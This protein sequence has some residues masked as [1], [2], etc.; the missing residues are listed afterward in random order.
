MKKLR[1]IFAIL[2][3]AALLLTLGACHPKNEV[4]ITAKDKKSGKSV[5]LTTAEYLYALTTATQEAQSIITES[6][7][8][9][10]IKD[11][12]KQKVEE[13]NENGK[14]T[15]TEYYKWIEARAEEILRTYAGISIKQE[16]LKLE[17]DEAAEANIESLVPMLYSPIYEQNG[18]GQETY[19]KLAKAG[20]DEM[21]NLYGS[22]YG[23]STYKELYF[24]SIYDEKGSNPV[25][26]ATIESYFKD[27]FVLGNQISI[28]IAEKS[29]D[30]EEATET[31]G[32]TEKEAKKLLNGYKERIEKGESFEKVF[33]EYAKKYET[34]TDES[35]GETT[36][37][38][39]EEAA[40]VYAS[41]ETGDY[42]SEFFD[43][44][45]KLKTGDVKVILSED[46]TQMILVE[47][48]NI[49]K[50]DEYLEG[51]HNLILHLLKDEEFNKD[52][53]KFCKGL[54]LEKH[55]RAYNRIDVKDIDLTVET[56]ETEE[57]TDTEESTET[58]ED[59]E[60]HNHE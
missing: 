11:F 4:A 56:P 19:T 22:Y 49:S 39:A 17:F 60:G 54:D 24:L 27:N 8:D 53:E 33:D 5:D 47:K 59:H 46:K 25:D 14:K 40:T 30:A 2:L 58:E 51:Y 32:M 43:A 48:Q 37:P 36:T 6:N 38:S 21:V 41:E 13:T 18:V 34:T 42:A 31:E 12:S 20:V 23:L 52:L 1:G 16:D 45:N 15:K 7:P 9:K 26:D 50:E 3:S 10:E 44:V 28:A 29:D 57:T 35:T 55:S